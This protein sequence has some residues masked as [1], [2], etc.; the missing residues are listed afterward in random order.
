M[1]VKK[2]L[3]SG[4]L[5]ASLAAPANA[6]QSAPA[7]PRSPAQAQVRWPGLAPGV[8]LGL[9]PGV[10]ARDITPKDNPLQTRAAE[11]APSAR[12]PWAEIGPAGVG[13]CA[14]YAEYYRRNPD[15]VDGSYLHWVMGYMSGINLM[16]LMKEDLYF[17]LHAKTPDEMMR[18]LRLYCNE[19]P[20][21][22]Y[23]EGVME[24]LKTLP[25]LQKKNDLPP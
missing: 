15:Q 4:A 19:H 20:L 24:L 12:E 11:P 7:P 10:L 25:M 16:I 23:T 1:T 8:P 2:L 18:Y 14:K 13:S 6:Q 3:A 21:A 9:D 22:K 17:D 5:L